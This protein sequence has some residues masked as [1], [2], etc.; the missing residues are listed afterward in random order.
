[1]AGAAGTKV[2]L[3]V[4]GHVGETLTVAMEP[5]WGFDRIWT[6][7]PASACRERLR[8]LA[9]ERVTVVPAGLWSSD[10]TMEPH[11]PGTL[12][13]SIDA[14]ASRHG[15][16]EECRFIDAAAWMAE[17][18]DDGDRVWMKVNVE[19][20]ARAEEDQVISTP[21]AMTMVGNRFR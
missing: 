13:A 11:D 9:D 2:F 17:H 7:E 4:G 5:R 20:V 12:H 3:D 8:A 18:V 10:T 16:T 14:A 6:F 1:M 21:A 15:Q 19:C